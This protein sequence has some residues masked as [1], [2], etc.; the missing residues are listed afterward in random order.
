MGKRGGAKTSMKTQVEEIFLVFRV[1]W[2]VF[3]R[4]SG[5]EM[6]MHVFWKILF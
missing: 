3:P 1:S 4:L 5:L 2:N 6:C